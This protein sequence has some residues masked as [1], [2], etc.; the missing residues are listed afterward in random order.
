MATV[1]AC[2]ERLSIDRVEALHEQILAA[3]SSVESIEIDASKV[4]YAD[5]AG[6]QLLLAL[7][8]SLQSSGKGLYWQGASDAVTDC[9]ALLGLNTLLQLSQP[10][11]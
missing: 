8:H 5:T 6:L 1:I 7:Q 10:Q 11:E 3:L 9:A 4:Q 2:G